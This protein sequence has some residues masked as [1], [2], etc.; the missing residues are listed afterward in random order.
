LLKFAQ[1]NLLGDAASSPASQLLRHCWWSI[2]Y[3]SSRF[4]LDGRQ[5]D[6]QPLRT[7]IRVLVKSIWQVNVLNHWRT[8]RLRFRNYY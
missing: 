4:C 5:F 3:W 7:S 6:S 1:K 8:I 2:N